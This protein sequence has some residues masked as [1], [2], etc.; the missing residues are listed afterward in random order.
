M[1]H[2]TH[3]P[4]KH[5]ANKMPVLFTAPSSVILSLKG[6][7]SAKFS[8]PLL[9][10]GLADLPNLFIAEC[11]D[12]NYLLLKSYYELFGVLVTNLKIRADL[13]NL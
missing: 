1:F 5:K 13:S 10:A 11:L 2:P 8:K 3:A 6:R 4:P 9:K 12:I 7:D